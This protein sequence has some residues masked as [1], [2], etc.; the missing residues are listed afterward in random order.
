MNPCTLSFNS[1][2]HALLSIYVRIVIPKGKGQTKRHVGRT[3]IYKSTLQNM[4]TKF[5]GYILT[6]CVSK[7]QRE[8]VGWD[9]NVS[10]VS[11]LHGTATNFTFHF[12]SR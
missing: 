1:C 2:Y 11:G 5:V 10:K 6:K 12:R 8:K 7:Q 3:E 9:E 4:K